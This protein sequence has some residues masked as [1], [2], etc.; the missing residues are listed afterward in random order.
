VIGAGPLLDG[1]RVLDAGSFIAGPLAAMTLGDW[2]AEVIKLESLDGDAAR[3]IGEQAGPGMSATFVACNRG[4]RSIALDLRGEAARADV[5]RLAAGCDVVIHN[6]PAAFAARLGLDHASLVQERPDAI[7]C[8]VSAFGETG[9]YAGRPALDPVVQ[10]LAGMSAA[11]GPVDGEPFRCAAPI[12]DT[13]TGYAAT[14][15]VLAALHRRGAG[16]G[17]AHVAVSLLDVAL[18]FQGPLLAL[19]SLLGSVPPRRG[20]ASFAVLGDQLPAADGLLAF[21][22]WD[23]RRWAALC[24]AAGVD[25]AVARDP[26]FSSAEARCANQDEL[27]PVLVDAFARWPARDLERVLLDAGIP[28]AVTQDLDGVVR[29]PQVQ[30]TG[31]VYE[32]ARLDGPGV[33]LAAGPVHVDGARPVRDRPPPRL[34]EHT[35]E[36]SAELSAGAHETMMEETR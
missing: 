2:G 11:T 27:R 24:A 8:T 6:L 25:E 17:G 28:C 5:R 29:D 15:A 33:V 20:N 12:V 7:L 22:V 26:R 35:H 10:A 9:P 36:L 3:W 14:A 4:K 32:E 1:L 13:A 21:V 23:D 19:R 16:G 18:A 30:A 34:G 31:A